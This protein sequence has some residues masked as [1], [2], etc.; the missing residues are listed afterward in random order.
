MEARR[1]SV[2]RLRAAQGAGAGGRLPQARRQFPLALFRPVLRRAD[3]IELHDAVAH[4]Q[5]RPV[6]RAVCRLGRPRRALWRR[7]RACDDARQY[8][9]AR[10]RADGRDGDRRSGAGPRP[11]FARLRRRQYPQRHRRRD[12][13]DRS[14]GAYRYAAAGAGMAFPHPQRPLADRPAAQVQRRLR[15]RR[16]R[17]PT[18]EETNDIGFQAVRV[19][20]GAGVEPG[21]WFRVVIGGITGHRDLA[22]DVGVVCRAGGMH[23]DRRRDR[24][25][26]H[27]Q[28]RPHRPRQGAAQICARRLGRG[29]IPRRGRGQARPAAHPC[30]RDGDRRSP[31]S[32]SRGAYRRPSPRRRRASTGSALRCRSAE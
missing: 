12:G 1:T 7:L 5:W 19:G 23:G 11:M 2:R 3:A 13:G 8:P 15:R 27:R 14:A 30:R 25:G 17:S 16:P 20:E 22:R 29:E 24:A 6:A 28:R 31:A 21:V 10:D 18:L 32:R 4:P 26:V 9:D